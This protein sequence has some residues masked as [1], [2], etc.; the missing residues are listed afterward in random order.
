MCDNIIL[1]KCINIAKQLK[2]SIMVFS[3]SG[4]PFE[5]HFLGLD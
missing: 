1:K 3:V 5:Y 2:G 4:L